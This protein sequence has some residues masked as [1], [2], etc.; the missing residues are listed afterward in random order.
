[1]GEAKRRGTYEQRKAL[2]IERDIRIAQQRVFTQRRRPS[3]KHMVLMS[4]LALVSVPY[5]GVLCLEQTGTK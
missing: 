1:M 2:A 4:A 5:G 3:G